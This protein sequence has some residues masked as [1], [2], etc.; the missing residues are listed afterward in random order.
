MLDGTYT[1]LKA[2]VANFLNRADLT[3]SIP[4]FITLAEAQMTRRFVSRMKEG[5]TFP[6]RLVFRTDAAIGQGME[7]FTVPTDM[8][9]PLELTFDADPPVDLDYLENAN[10]QREVK[11]NRWTGAPKWYSVVGAEFRIYPAADQAYTAELT[12]I[13]RVPA[14][15]DAAPSNWI[16]TDYPDAYLYGA[17]VQAWLF[18]KD[19]ARAQSAAVPYTTAIDDICD[20]D[21]MP[22]EK[23]VLR[24]DLPRHRSLLCG[25]NPLTDC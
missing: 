19:E 5:K 3:A 17:I 14:L 10:L 18:L 7:Y 20:S 23:A 25:W 16:L 2:S 24:T 12:Y 6:R 11:L 21:P 13:A 22:T 15:T 9:G 8:Q 1:G 4:D